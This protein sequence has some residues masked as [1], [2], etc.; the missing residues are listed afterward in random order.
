MKVNLDLAECG[1]IMVALLY[2]DMNLRELMKKQI[3]HELWEKK[4]TQNKKL[5]IKIE[6]VWQ[7]ELEKVPK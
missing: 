1:A 2:R 5:L 4:I 7:H 3:N 6:E